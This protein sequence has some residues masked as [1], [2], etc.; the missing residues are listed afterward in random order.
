MYISIKT[1]TDCEG[2]SW[3]N[4]L[5]IQNFLGLVPDFTD[6]ESVALILLVK[7]KQEEFLNIYCMS[8]VAYLDTSD[9]VFV[10]FITF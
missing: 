2:H 4:I 5:N 7:F 6:S 9:F 1:I 8:C 10:S 3:K